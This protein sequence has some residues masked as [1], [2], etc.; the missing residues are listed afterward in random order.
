[1]EANDTQLQ[2]FAMRATYSQ[3]LK[4]QKKLQQLGLESF[5][6]MNYKIA[7]RGGKKVRIEVPLLNNYIFVRGTAQDIYK[8]KSQITYIRYVMN[9]SNN[10]IIVPDDQMQNFMRVAS[11]KDKE[12]IYFTPEEINF[13]QDTR[14]RV[15]GGVFDG[16]EGSFIKIEG[17]RKK[18]LLVTL[19]NL[20]AITTIVDPTLI[21]IL[22]NR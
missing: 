17:K 20:L 22:P 3:E 16:V 11:V 19:D 21:E 9:H 18:R 13:K 15:H 12:T 7:I 1:M 10:K 6:P 5:V 14:I 4:S 2:W 8:A